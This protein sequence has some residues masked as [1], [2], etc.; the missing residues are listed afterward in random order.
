VQAGAKEPAP[1]AVGVAEGELREGRIGYAE[2]IETVTV[3][4]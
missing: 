2:G 4:V 1:E 3:A